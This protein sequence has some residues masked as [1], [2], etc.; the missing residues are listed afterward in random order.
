[1]LRQPSCTGMRPA[2]RHRGSD[3]LKPV[4]LQ[5]GEVTAEVAAGVYFQERRAV[6]LALRRV[7]QAAAAA[8]A[9]LAPDVADCVAAFACGLLEQRRDG[10][11]AL[12]GRLLTLVQVRGPSW[13]ETVAASLPCE[14]I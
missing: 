1:M 13:D 10:R 7:L 3:Q 11:A 5:S 12:V 6:L 14:Q 8:A 4:S 9:G 2:S